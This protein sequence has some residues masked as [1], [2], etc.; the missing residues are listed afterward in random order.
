L[1]CIQLKTWIT[2]PPHDFIDILL[3]KMPNLF[4]SNKRIG[5]KKTE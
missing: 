5:V 3:K 1:I 4:K 2:H